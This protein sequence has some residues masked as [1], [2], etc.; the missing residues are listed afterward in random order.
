MRGSDYLLQDNKIKAFFQNKG[1]SI[2]F[3]PR[4]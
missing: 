3:Q 1:V 2:A 4:G